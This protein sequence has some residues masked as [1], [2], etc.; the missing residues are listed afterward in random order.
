MSDESNLVEI[1]GQELDSL[2]NYRKSI[3]KEIALLEARKEGYLRR[4]ELNEML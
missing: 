4:Y 1:Y 3:M 2:N